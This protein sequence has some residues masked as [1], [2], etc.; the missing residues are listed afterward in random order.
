MK[1]P[2]LQSLLG[3]K[4]NGNWLLRTCEIWGYLQLN[5]T[6]SNVELVDAF[7][8]RGVSGF[9]WGMGEVIKEVRVAIERGYKHS[10]SPTLECRNKRWSLKKGNKRGN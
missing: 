2:T 6:A 9:N 7:Q 8:R 1:R 10:V 4:R 3:R 5:P